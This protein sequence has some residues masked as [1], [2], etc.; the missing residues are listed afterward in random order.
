MTADPAT[1]QPP[2]STDAPTV[3]V[4]ARQLYLRLAGPA[5][6]DVLNVKSKAGPEV[7]Q[8][9]V[10]A[11]KAE[12]TRMLGALPA[13]DPGRALV[14]QRLGEIERIVDDPLEWH[15][16]ERA[17]AMRLDA[18]DPDVRA[19]L[20][21]SFLERHVP[22]AVWLNAPT[23][24]DQSELRKA[25]RLPLL[26]DVDVETK[27]GAV[28]AMRTDNLSRTGVCL[29]EVPPSF[30]ASSVK[31]TIKLPGDGR[32]IT[33]A[34][35]VAW[36]RADRAG[37]AF[38]GTSV[39][40]ELA[41]DQALQSHFAAVRAL[42]ERYLALA[43][44]DPTAL[45]S[46]GLARFFSTVLPNERAAARD[47]LYAH[48]DEH[49]GA[50]E[51]QLAAARVALETSDLARAGGALKRA[52]KGARTDPRYVQLDEAYA[53]K[54]GAGRRLV[55]AI[56]AQSVAAQ[57]GA[58]GLTLLLLGGAGTW[59]VLATRS[60]YRSVSLPE[61]ALPCEQTKV[62]GRVALC[63]V[64]FAKWTGLSPEQRTVRADATLSALAAFSIQHLVV[65]DATRGNVL[66]T[67][68][69]IPSRAR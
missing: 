36:R 29:C 40:D 51:L 30:D 64:P 28:H 41:L 48:A 50:V 65:Y 44:K 12:V 5:F 37:V 23:A 24:L 6:F 1:T 31:L 57:A 18:A 45:A 52:E 17:H 49:P 33:L 46:V 58:L 2:V 69:T 20:E 62:Q 54:G 8:Q 19:R 9:R 4:D 59:A 11:L 22:R 56:R 68:G 14:V 38:T 66:Q 32:R 25:M 27:G 34:G 35:K 13:D 7:L 26:A 55:R 3:P 16:L 15:I 10:A 67:F 63:F 39:A 53:K 61:T 21:A 60:G 43:P 47:Q 42:A